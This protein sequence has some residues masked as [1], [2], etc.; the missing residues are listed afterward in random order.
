MEYSIL[1]LFHI[2]ALILWLGPALGAWLVFKAVEKEEIS[3]VTEKVNRVFFAMITIEHIAFVVLLATG[4][5]MAMTAGWF[6]AGM[7]GAPWLSQKLMVIGLIIIPLEIVDLVLG[8]WLA[9]KAS[10]SMYSGE[11]INQ[12]QKRWL[13]IYHGPFTKL[14]I[15]LIPI[16]VLLVMYLAVNKLPLF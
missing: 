1:K 13:E 6:S 4:F 11:A 3:P 5:M 8:N 2:G 9:L 10:N 14:A 16:S 12:K 15:A 7:S